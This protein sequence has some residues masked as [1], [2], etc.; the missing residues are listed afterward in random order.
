MKIAYIGID[1]LLPVLKSLMA[2]NCE[3][4][5]I[6]TCETDNITEFNTEII[7]T[8]MN[9]NIPYSLNRITVHDFDRLLEKGC[10]AVFCAGYYYKIPVYPAIPTINVHPSLLPYGRGSWPMP[11]D[12]LNQKT[13]SGVTFHK[14]AEG[15]D[16]GDILLQRKFLLDKNENHATLMEKVYKLIPDMISLL[17]SDFVSFYKNA[18][19]QGDGEYLPLPEKSMYTVDFN[20]DINDADRILRAF[21]G[22]DCYY[23]D[24]NTETV[25]IGARAVKGELRPEDKG[26]NT[27]PVCGGY[28]VV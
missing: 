5:E 25:I 21:F 26:K 16:E 24:G 11:Y 14:V 23:Y 6:F 1:L 18:V 3:I 8:A 13:F 4:L 22:Y 12:I 2:N 7:K 27:F 28:I 20:T 15:F 19:A 10:E 9:N 17:M